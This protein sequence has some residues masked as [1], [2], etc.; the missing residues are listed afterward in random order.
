M[1][2]HHTNPYSL[3][4]GMIVFSISVVT[5]YLYRALLHFCFAMSTTKLNEAKEGFVILRGKAKKH[6]KQLIAPLSNE[7]CLGYLYMVIDKSKKDKIVYKESKIVDFILVDETGQCLVNPQF[8]GSF[9]NNALWPP[10]IRFNDSI[11]ACDLSDKAKYNRFRHRR[12]RHM[13]YRRQEGEPIYIEG[14]YQ[15]QDSLINEELKLQG[16]IAGQHKKS[17]KITP[18]Y[19]GG[20][21]VNYSKFSWLE[22]L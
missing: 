15:A 21:V 11:D 12:Y 9:H 20:D 8:I 19:K 14:F 2:I 17:L 10:F 16:K 13:E 4:I 18:A 22:S 7:P 5:H 1:L 3:A 6:E